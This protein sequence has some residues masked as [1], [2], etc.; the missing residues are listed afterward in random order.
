MEIKNLEGS[1][2]LDI[3][4]NKSDTLVK[5][6]AIKLDKQDLKSEG[7]FIKA[8]QEGTSS[9]DNGAYN[10]HHDSGLF[11]RFNVKNKRITGLHRVSNNTGIIMPCWSYFTE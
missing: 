2:E 8:L 10:V 7:D 11:A 9:L 1:N 6:G 5:V 3:F 4:F